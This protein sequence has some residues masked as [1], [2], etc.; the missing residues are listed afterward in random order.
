MPLLRKLLP[1]LLLVLVFFI[2]D[3]FFGPVA[4]AACALLLGIAEFIHVRLREKRND[5]LVAGTTLLFCIPGIASLSDTPLLIRLQAGITEVGLCAILGVFAF[6]RKEISSALP[7]SARSHIEISHEQQREMKK[8]IRVLFFILCV[9]TLIVFYSALFLKESAAGFVSGPLLYLLAGLFFVSVFIRNRILIR[10]F[11]REEWLPVVNE[12]G[13]ISG[14]ATRTACH[15]GS[16]LLHPVVHLHLIRTDGS[17]FLQ[18]RSLK[19]ELLPGKW[20]TAVGGHVGLNERI[21]DALKRETLEELGIES[22]EAQF[23]GSY[24]WESKQEKELVFSFT[25]KR[26]GPIRIDNDEVDEGRFWSRQEIGQSLN[27]DLF[28]PNFIHEYDRYL[29]NRTKG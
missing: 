25:A 13:E 24:V 27:E 14:K 29:T 28:T 3:E 6:S 11:R 7:A 23:N 12:K 2:A 8:T 18:K 19:K 22:F 20:D 5:W 17:I 4:G 1:A 15:S 9:H 21:E 10:R 16:K 26:F